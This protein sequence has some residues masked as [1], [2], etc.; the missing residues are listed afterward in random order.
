MEAQ[1]CLSGVKIENALLVGT[2]LLKLLGQKG[3]QE[4]IRDT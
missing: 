4:V 3:D 1:H 2:Y